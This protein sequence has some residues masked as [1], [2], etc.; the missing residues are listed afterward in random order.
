MSG[1][2]DEVRPAM[3]P[4]GWQTLTPVPRIVAQPR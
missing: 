2:H 4:N 1:P 3:Y